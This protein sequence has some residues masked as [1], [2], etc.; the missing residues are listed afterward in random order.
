MTT[1]E[2]V[3]RIDRMLRDCKASAAPAVLLAA[4]CCAFAA[5]VVLGALLR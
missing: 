1:I 4:A 3:R 2:H 5:F